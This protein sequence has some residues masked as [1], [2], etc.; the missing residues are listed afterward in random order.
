ETTLKESLT[1]VI[2]TSY[3]IER[4][5]S[6]FF[7]TAKAKMDSGYDFPM[8]QVA[9]ATSAA[10]IFFEPFKIDTDDTID[11][12]ALI[13]GGVFAN[14][15]AMC[16]YVEAKSTHSD[17]DD[18][19]IVS[20][21]TGQSS[22]PILYDEAKDWGLANWA[23][24][25][26]NVVFDGVSD[27]VEYQLQ[28]LLSPECYYRFQTR[29][30]DDNDDMDDASRENIRALKLLAQNIIQDNSDDLNRLCEQLVE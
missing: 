7:R 23:L 24:P 27:T 18:L 20:L 12:Y 10:P 8:W 30:S 15:P 19:L 9:R 17:T 11:Y 3:E 5:I 13:D 29:L 26:L 16:A 22:R 1:D 28:R 21:G 2:I 6:W 4:R 25:I 14:N